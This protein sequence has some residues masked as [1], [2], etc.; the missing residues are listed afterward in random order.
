VVGLDSGAALASVF[1]TASL[2][3]STAVKAVAVFAAS[4]FGGS[5]V[6]VFCA[7]GLAVLWTCLE[8]DSGRATDEDIMAGSTGAPGTVA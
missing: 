5:G 2:G 6:V 7:A 3:G 1:G 8:A 4:V